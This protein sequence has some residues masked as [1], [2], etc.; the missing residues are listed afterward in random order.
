[1]VASC[2]ANADDSNKYGGGSGGSPPNQPPPTDTSNPLPDA[3]RGSFFDASPPTDDSQPPPDASCFADT[4]TAQRPPLAMYIMMDKSGSM[5]DPPNILNPFVTKWI[6]VKNAL[7]GFLNDQAS[8]GIS[9]A[10]QYFPLAAKALSEFRTC[11]TQDD[12]GT[13]AVCLETDETLDHCYR[14]CTSHG[15]CGD[16]ECVPLNNGGYVC[17]NDSC[18]ASVYARPE[19]EFAELPGAQGRIMA[20]LNAHKP[21]SAT[22]TLPALQG[23]VSHASEWAQDHP[24]HKVIVVLATDGMP[25]VC[26][27][28]STLQQRVQQAADAAAGGFAATPSIKTFVVGIVGP[29]DGSLPHLQKMAAAGGTGQALIVQANADVTAE[30]SEALAKI[31]GAALACD[32]QLPSSGTGPLDYDTVNVLYSNATVTESTIYYVDSEASCHPQQ[33]GWYYDVNPDQG[34][35][36][37]IVVCPATCQAAQGDG[38]ATFSVSVGC[39]TQTG[40]K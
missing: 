22:P 12:C 9:V 6:A 30:F 36:T 10:I 11:T 8:A 29:T 37:R 40:P 25:T 7:A 17:G 32:F 1:A 4:Q 33:G 14:Q 13:E 3:G 18:N 24:D 38:A 2:S 20:S 27:I 19:V 21:T 35:P 28:D 15:P 39:Q 31:R 34:K 23:A 5:I 26:S 16:A